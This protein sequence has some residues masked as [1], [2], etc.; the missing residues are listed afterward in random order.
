MKRQGKRQRRSRRDLEEEGGI[1]RCGDWKTK[2]WR[3]RGMLRERDEAFLFFFFMFSFSQYDGHPSKRPARIECCWSSF[4]L[5]SS[6]IILCPFFFLSQITTKRRVKFLNPSL[7]QIVSKPGRQMESWSL[8][9]PDNN[10]LG[11][12]HIRLNHGYMSLQIN[13]CQPLLT[14]QILCLS[15]YHWCPKSKNKSLENGRLQLR[16]EVFFCLVMCFLGQHFLYLC[17]PIFWFICCSVSAEKN[18]VWK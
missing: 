7:I 9:F 5:I 8:L 16:S 17:Q 15:A 2:G 10:H 1:G 4:R 14:A 11:T 13:L 18:A 12:A 3:Q 6:Q